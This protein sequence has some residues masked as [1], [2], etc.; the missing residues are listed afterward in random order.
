MRGDAQPVE[1]QGY[2]SG[3]DGEHRPAG[4]AGLHYHYRGPHGLV[5]QWPALSGRSFKPSC[6]GVGALVQ[7]A[8]GKGRH[9][10]PGLKLGIC[11]EHGGD[12]ASIA[13]CQQAGLDYVSYSPY[14]VPVARLAAAQ[15]KLKQVIVHE[16][17]RSNS[18]SSFVR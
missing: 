1:P 13:F 5:C 12:P 4:A 18:R 11:G 7:F 17:R 10:K 6:E 14:L 2:E 9:T 8:A 16:E 3:R 15:A